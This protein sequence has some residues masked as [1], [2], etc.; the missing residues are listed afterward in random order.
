MTIPAHFDISYVH[1]EWSPQCPI[2]MWLPSVLHYEYINTNEKLPTHYSSLCV[3][4][5]TGDPSKNM[6]HHCDL[7]KGRKNWAQL[8]SGLSCCLVIS[9]CGR[10]APLVWTQSRG[11]AL[12][13]RN[14]R[15]SDH[16]RIS[17]LPR[18]IL[19]CTK[20]KETTM[21]VFTIS[22]S[23]NDDKREGCYNS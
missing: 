23:N 5:F 21:V 8:L 1:Q 11:L 18:L 17:H 6:L 10:F 3:C 2:I 4:E 13:I 16:S 19:Y 7:H 12:K 9:P 15:S 14:A 22:V 20:K